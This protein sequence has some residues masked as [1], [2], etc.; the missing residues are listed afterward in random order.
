MSMAMPVQE[1]RSSERPVP[2]RGRRDLIVKKI[3]FQG[4]T[5]FVI[6]DP[7]GLTYHRLRADQYHVLESLDGQ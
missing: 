7:V 6:K 4:V 5:H 2:L 1:M 3:D